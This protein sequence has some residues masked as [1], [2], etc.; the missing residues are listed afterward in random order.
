[1]RELVCTLPECLRLV[2]A[3]GRFGVSKILLRLLQW[4]SVIGA[5]CLMGGFESSWLER[6]SRVRVRLQGLL[7][8]TW[9]LVLGIMFYDSRSQ[10]RF[11]S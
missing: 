9:T 7:F 2:V 3:A 8:G 1:M 5:T 4:G 10:A 6:G 11:L